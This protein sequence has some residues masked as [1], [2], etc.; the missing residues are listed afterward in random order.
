MLNTVKVF[1]RYAAKEELRKVLSQAQPVVAGHIVTLKKILLRMALATA[2][3][4]RRR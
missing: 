4:A 2:A 3:A 1:K